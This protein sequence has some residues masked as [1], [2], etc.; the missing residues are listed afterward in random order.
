MI[1]DN[2]CIDVRDSV[3][4]ELGYQ[5]PHP[6]ARDVYVERDTLA[7]NLDTS[8]APWECRAAIDPG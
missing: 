7:I 8:Q 3:R 6:A 4:G 5:L 2:N 1:V